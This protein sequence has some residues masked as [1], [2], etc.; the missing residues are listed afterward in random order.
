MRSPHALHWNVLRWNLDVERVQSLASILVAGMTTPHTLH[1]DILS[2]NFEVE[3]IDMIH[4]HNIG[5]GGSMSGMPILVLQCSKWDQLERE[6]P[7]RLEISLLQGAN[8]DEMD[9]NF[10]GT[11]LAPWPIIS[12]GFHSLGHPAP[13]SLPYKTLSSGPKVARFWEGV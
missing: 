10:H 12:T 13:C 9:C 5:Y 7:N 3:H 11:I 2:W 1:S 8:I 6:A 4:G